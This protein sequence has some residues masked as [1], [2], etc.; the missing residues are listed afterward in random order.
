[1]KYART[2]DGFIYKITTRNFGIFVIDEKGKLIGRIDADEIIKQ[3]DNIEE[4]C[5][6]IAIVSENQI[7]DVETNI[8]G[9]FK[10]EYD[11]VLPEAKAEYP[12]EHWNMYLG[13]LT[14]KGLIYVAE[15][16]D[17]GELELL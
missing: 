9:Y 16:N 10:Y 6:F 8:R 17:K 5:D 13:I 12:E 3:A 4:L 1:M 7:Y 15:M 14:D 2:K 11:Q